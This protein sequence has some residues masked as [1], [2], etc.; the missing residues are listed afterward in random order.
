MGQPSVQANAVFAMQRMEFC[1]TLLAE[2]IVVA[3]VKPHL[4]ES[5]GAIFNR[6]MLISHIILDQLKTKDI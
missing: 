1:F 2:A 5:L 3:I 4:A 6:F